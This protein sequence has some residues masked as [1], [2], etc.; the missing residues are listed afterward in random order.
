MDL[1]ELRVQIDGT[2]DEIIRLF[3]QRMD[4]SAEIAK[5]KRQHDLPI[6]D[7]AREQQK[8][9]DMAAKVKKEHA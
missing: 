2:D 4:I 9:R 3:R 7:P 6:R 5:Y 8:L 1:Q